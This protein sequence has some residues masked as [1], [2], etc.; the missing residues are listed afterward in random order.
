[1][2]ISIISILDDPNLDDP[3]VPEIAQQCRDDRDEY[4]RIARMYTLKYATGDEPQVS[5][6]GVGSPWW[7]SMEVVTVDP[8]PE[9]SLY[10]R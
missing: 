5:P 9:N 2:L 3:L 4:N 1:M 8:D 6:I 7:E 10:A